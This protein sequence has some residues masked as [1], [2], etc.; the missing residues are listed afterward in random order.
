MAKRRGGAVPPTPLTAKVV[1]LNYK[2]SL[3]IRRQGRRTVSPRF[4]DIFDIEAR[5]FAAPESAGK[6]AKQNRAT[7]IWRRLSAFDAIAMTISATAAFCFALFTQSR[8]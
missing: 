7:L 6:T 1:P 4:L 3:T 5:K 2:S 8:A